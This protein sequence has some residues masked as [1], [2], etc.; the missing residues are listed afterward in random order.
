MDEA[1]QRALN[2]WLQTAIDNLE[3][4]D[5]DCDFEEVQSTLEMCQK[6]VNG[7]PVLTRIAQDFLAEEKALEAK[8]M[9]TRNHG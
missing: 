7:D 1:I 3:C 9:E 8:D 6:L 4:E 2:N 5:I